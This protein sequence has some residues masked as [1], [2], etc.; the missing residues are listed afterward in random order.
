M[1]FHESAQ[2]ITVKDGHI[3]KAQLENGDGEF[4]DAEL[5]LNTCLGNN[6]GSFQWGGENFADSAQ[7]ISFDL[8]GDDSAPILRA[9]LGNVEGESAE[10]DVNLSECITNEGGEFQFN[11][12]E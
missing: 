7:D 2:D 6:D 12:P 4:V 10:C 5:D 9:T 8:E 1:T 3:L 11:N